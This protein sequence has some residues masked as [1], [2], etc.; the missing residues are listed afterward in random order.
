MTYRAWLDRYATLAVGDGRSDQLPWADITWQQRFTDMLQRTEAR[1]SPVDS[2]EIPTMFAGTG[3]TD[4]PH[5]AI[6]AL[7]SVYPEIETDVL[8][9]ADVAFFF[10]LCRTPGKPVNFVPVIDKDVRRWWRSDSLWQA[11]D[12]R[13]P[14]DAV[15]II[16]GPVAVSGITRVDEPV[17]ELLD[18][19]EAQVVNDLQDAG[20][21][22]I[23][24]DTRKRAGLVDGDGTIV[25]VLEADDVDWVGRM[26]PNPIALLGDRD[27]W[28]LV[29]PD[30]AE[31]EP[32]GSVLEHVAEDR[33]DLVTP[34]SGSSVRIPLHIDAGLL[35]GGNPR[36]GIDE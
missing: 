23:A 9:P 2:G 30:R 33:Y 25:A 28:T 1:M 12:E 3:S 19:F 24:V 4:D 13:Y 20:T 6:D 17:G 29:D 27:R 10:E 11:H 18:R 34:I 8:H 26:V 32:T 15:C 21:D 14:A 31:H 7:G 22:S 36:V 5:S 16:P 35:D